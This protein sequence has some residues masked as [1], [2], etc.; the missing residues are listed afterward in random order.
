MKPLSNDPNDSSNELTSVRWYVRLLRIG[1]AVAL[2]AGAVGGA[3]YLKTSAPKTT[4]RQPVKWVPAV[5]VRTLQ[6]TAHQVTL[7][8]MGTVV[9][10]RQV[11]LRSRLAGSVA[12][13]HPEFTAGG[14]IAA[15]ERVVQ[16]DDTDYRLALVQK[17]SDLVNERYALS[18]ELGRQAVARREWGLLNGTAADGA[19]DADLALRKPHLEKARADVA[20]AEAALQKAALDLSRTRIVAPFNA[21]VRATKVDVGSE[22]TPQESLAELVG[23]DAYQ[24]QASV[25]TDRLGWIAIPAGTGE[26]GAAAVIRYAGGHRVDGRVVRLL[27]DLSDEG[28]M[29][30]LLIE[31]SDPLG[32]GAAGEARPPLLIGEYVHVEIQGSRLERVFTVPRTAL[33]DNETVWLVAPDNTLRIRP[34]VPLWR[35]ADA[36]VLS[37]GLKA[38]DLLVVSDLPAPVEGMAV[39]LATPAGTEPATVTPP[40]EGARP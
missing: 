5:Q 16:L 34:V 11:V 40:T 7:Q 29:A 6:P 28:R 22:I 1:V 23:T 4:R 21:L 35:D 10:A 24:V 33:R 12:A 37:D 20:A 32:R 27:G 19:A 38:G 17:E 14:V 8:A 31:I 13:V 25:P 18:L 9:P 39:R 2:V 30:R 36:V 15:G 26:P 3:Y